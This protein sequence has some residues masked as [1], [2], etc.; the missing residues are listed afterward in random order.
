VQ[1]FGH[2]TPPVAANALDG[3]L[4]ER[5]EVVTLLTGV[6]VRPQ[7][8]APA[9]SGESRKICENQFVTVN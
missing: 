5:S 2:K 9:Y 3:N 4:I 7:N 6:F 8:H 1:R